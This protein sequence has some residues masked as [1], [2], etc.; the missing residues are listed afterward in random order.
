MEIIIKGTAKEIADLIRAIQDRQNNWLSNVQLDTSRVFSEPKAS[1][2]S[3]DLESERLRA[4]KYAAE[5]ICQELET[6]AQSSGGTCQGALWEWLKE[7]NST[8]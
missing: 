2:T 8:D 5:S 3:Q 1:H 4:S 6:R 7:K